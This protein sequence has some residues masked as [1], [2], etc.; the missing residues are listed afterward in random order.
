MT[1]KD[2]GIM[3]TI[4]KGIVKLRFVILA[5]AVF[6][7]IP[8]AFGYINTRVNYD[9]LSYLPKE[10]ETNADKTLTMQY[11]INDKTYNVKIR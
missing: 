5:V 9:I 2:G 7:L 11:K 4:S 3:K 1:E 10:I 6:L 8:S